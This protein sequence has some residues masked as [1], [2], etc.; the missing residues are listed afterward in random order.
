MANELVGILVANPMYQDYLTDSIKMQ[1]IFQPE[2]NRIF[3]ERYFAQMVGPELFM[4]A[5]SIT[6]NEIRFVSK[7]LYTASKKNEKKLGVKAYRAFELSIEIHSNTYL[8]R[9]ISEQIAQKVY[10]YRLSGS[11]T[12]LSSSYLLRMDLM[13]ELAEEVKG[14][15][16]IAMPSPELLLLTRNAGELQGDFAQLAAAV[17]QKE[18]YGE[19]GTKN[20]FVF[21]KDKGLIRRVFYDRLVSSVSY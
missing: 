5:A 17:Q 9:M 19:W 2:K 16:M 4:L 10:Q 20:L 3:R 14:D 6:G 15:L 7:R 1:P 11:F 21:Q 13:K 12:P 8:R 18:K